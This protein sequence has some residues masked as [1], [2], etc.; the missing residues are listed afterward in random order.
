MKANKS[1]FMELVSELSTLIVEERFGEDTFVDTDCG[2]RF[3]DEPQ[4][5]FNEQYDKVESMTANLLKIDID[6]LD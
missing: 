5:Y 2:T 3:G 4:D 1:D 6:E